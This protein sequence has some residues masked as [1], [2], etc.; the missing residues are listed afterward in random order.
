MK[1]RYYNLI[2]K[3]SKVRADPNLSGRA[4]IV[5]DGEHERKRKEQL[6]RLFSRTPEQV[7]FCVTKKVL[8]LEGVLTLTWYTYMCLP[9]GVLFLKFWYSNGGVIAD[10]DLQFT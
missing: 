8:S 5:F 4:P 6:T 9:F 3:L 2:N 1:E 7:I 10:E